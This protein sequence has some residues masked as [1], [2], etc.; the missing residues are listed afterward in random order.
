MSKNLLIALGFAV[1]GQAYR[2]LKCPPEFL[3]TD[4]GCIEDCK[5]EKFVNCPDFYDSFQDG[6]IHPHNHILNSEGF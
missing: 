3:W 5:A 1:F 4:R 2:P 6:S